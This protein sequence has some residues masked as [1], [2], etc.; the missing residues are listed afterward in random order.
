MKIGFNTSQIDVVSLD[1]K[2]KLFLELGCNAIEFSMAYLE[3]EKQLAENWDK[4]PWDKFVYKSLHAPVRDTAYKDDQGTHD[5]LG[6]LEK[7]QEK[8]GFDLM[9]FHPDVVEDFSIFKRYNLPVAFENMDNRKKTARDVES[10]KGI[11]SLIDAAMVLDLS[12]C[13]VNDNSMNLANE[14]Y[15]NFKDRIKEIH[16]SGHSTLHD[17]LYKTKQIEIIKAIP[18]KEIPIIIESLQETM[19][20]V[21]KEFAYVTDILNK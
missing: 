16:L 4:V 18:N 17:P 1:Q 9:V 5:L 15:L 13:Y 3:R 2:I 20:D 12:H 11:F 8:Y 21:K 7:L 10:F 6:R 14:F 19:D